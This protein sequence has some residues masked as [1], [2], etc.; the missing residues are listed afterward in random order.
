MQNLDIVQV[1]AK[2]FSGLSAKFFSAVSAQFFFHCPIFLSLPNLSFTAHSFFPCPLPHLLLCRTRCRS[3]APLLCCTRCRSCAPLLCCTRCRSCAPLLSCARCRSCAPL[4]S[5]GFGPRL[6]PVPCLAVALPSLCRALVI[7]S[8]VEKS[9]R[10]CS[11]PAGKWT[12]SYVLGVFSCLPCIKN[13]RVATP[14]APPPR[15]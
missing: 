9:L 3:C 13:D 6:L 12:T 14:S 1:F 15:D 4:L 2:S 5:C 10:R 8:E 11:Y 7:S